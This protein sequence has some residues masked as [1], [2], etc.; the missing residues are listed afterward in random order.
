MT[1]KNA[2]HPERSEGSF[3]CSERQQRNAWRPEP[4]V[5]LNEVKDL[6]FALNNSSETRVILNA[7]KDLLFALNDSSETRCILN[8]ESS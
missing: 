7:V 5:I 1:V 4:R 8:R 3:L 6:L 2:S